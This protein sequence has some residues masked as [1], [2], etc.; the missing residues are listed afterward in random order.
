M[1]FE[2][3]VQIYHLLS[4]LRS[5]FNQKIWWLEYLEYFKLFLGF[6][7]TLFSESC[8]NKKLSAPTYFAGLTI[9]VQSNLGKL[10][11]N[12]TLFHK[13]AIFPDSIN[14]VSEFICGCM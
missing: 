3:I 11:T 10:V 8:Q 9:F 1:L 5:R 12:F 6:K 13:Y 7:K 2:S 4:I 14:A